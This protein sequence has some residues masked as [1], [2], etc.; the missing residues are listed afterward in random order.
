MKM[1]NKIFGFV[2]FDF[3]KPFLL[4]PEINFPTILY[5]RDEKRFW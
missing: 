4:I 3:Y 1:E 5:T 2:I